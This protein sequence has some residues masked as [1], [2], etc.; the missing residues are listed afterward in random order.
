MLRVS[1]QYLL[2]RIGA[3]LIDA[4]LISLVLVLPAALLSWIVIRSGG[5]MNWIARI[6]NVTF[7]LFLVGL[8]VRDGWK[9]RSTGKLIMGLELKRGDG[10]RVGYGTS[11]LRN[12]TMILPFLNLVEIA[13]VLFSEG[14]RR[15][16]DRIA[17]TIVVEE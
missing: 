15:L 8:L 14:G 9:G 13:F 3:F 4:L 10:R 1:R 5:A 12:L 7:L 16:G 11:A 6:W 17:R 2:L